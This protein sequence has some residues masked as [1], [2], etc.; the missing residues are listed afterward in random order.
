MPN[1]LLGVTGSVA[2]IKA[3]KLYYALR[4]IGDIKVV[5]T[6]SSKAFVSYNSFSIHDRSNIYDDSHEWEWKAIGD[7]IQHID[8]K[9]WANIFVIAPL[10]ANTLAKI[11]NGICDNLL[12]S[13][14]RAWPISKKNVVVAPAMNTDMWEHPITFK[15]LADLSQIFT[16]KY[17]LT[18]EEYLKEKN[19]TS[20]WCCVEK[21][22]YYPLQRVNYRFKVVKPVVSKLAC[23]I[24]GKGA[25]API[26]DIVKATEEMLKE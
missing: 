4:E 24:T 9:D 12:T 21:G 16:S 11:S 7:P 20:D 3:P 13:I 22:I 25:M 26:E 23:G 6:E 10:S 1:I 8:L 19:N 5:I 2:A 15:Q 14:F 17:E 18:P